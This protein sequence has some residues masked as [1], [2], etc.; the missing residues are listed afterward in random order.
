MAAYCGICVYQ[1]NQFPDEYRGH[2]FMGNI[3]QNAINQDRLT[4]NGSS[5]K[6]TA[7]K[8][9]LTTSDGWFR[10]VSEQVGP[11]GALWIADWYDKYPCYQ[12][13]RADPEGVDR[14][15]GR[16]WRV[17]HNGKDP[18]NKIGSRPDRTM[19]LAKLNNRELVK[20]LEYPNI[21]H[22]RTAQRIL[23][24]RN[25]PRSG[26]ADEP[27]GSP[28]A[29]LPDVAK[30]L[31]KITSN[32]KTLEPRLAALWTLHA[33]NSVKDQ[34]STSPAIEGWPDLLIKLTRAPEPAVKVWAIR[35]LGDVLR[36]AKKDTPANVASAASASYETGLDR[37]EELAADRDPCVRCAVAVACREIVS[38]SLTVDTDL[39]YAAQVRR[40]L[41]RLTASS[42]DA[43]D[44]LIPYMIWM[45][46]E[47][48]FA[49]NPKGGLDWLAN[50]GAQ[51]MPLSGILARKAMRRIC[52]TQDKT[53][54]DI[55]VHFLERVVDTP[56]GV[57]RDAIEG[58]IEGQKAKPLVPNL[59]TTS[60]FARL[61]LS[62]DQHI[63]E[64][65][66]ELGTL[67]GNAASIEA[68]LKT[69]NDATLPV[70]Q[71]RKAI[72]AAKALKNQVARDA[73]LK[74]VNTDKDESLIVEAIRGL[75]DLGS[76]TVSDDLLAS[77]TKFTPPIKTAAAEVL[78]SRHRWAIALLSAIEAKR[79]S[80][81]E[82]PITAVRALGE[83]KD[84]FVRQRAVQAIGRI[85]AANTDKQ[86]IIEEKKTMILKGGLQDLNA[87]H[88]IAKKTCFVCHKLNGEGGEVGPDLTGVGR[89][90][91]DALLANVIDPNLVVGKGYENVIIE[92]KDGQTV[93]GRLV[94]NTD[95]R[96]KLLSL[97]PK[98]EFV[99][100]SDI[101][102]M[103]VSEL[104][105]M[106]EGLE[107]MPDADFRNMM[108]FI[109]E[110]TEK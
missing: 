1:G 62:T 106:P 24:E 60:L 9:F 76:D 46:G 45:A 29:G 108:L 100:K 14:E 99:A 80:P 35:F 87:G 39:D 86:K 110:G 89:S 36:S 51:N 42:K 58:L 54:M 40:V 94:E 4:P 65:G 56:A 73:L 68:T 63:K 17:V 50:D 81:M 69:L 96:V 71:R 26:V 43:R 34:S 109:L 57:A 20:L 19:D 5:F 70:E 61:K 6:A 18:N 2:V 16:I 8:D 7:E 21:W 48:A 78:V 95:S 33:V 66:Q 47:P 107:Q 92:T 74:L 83:S 91:L 105:V 32:S 15:H 97:G 37:L 98:E 77:W 13:A 28:T 67:W 72:V 30:E 41:A 55:V 75:G 82:L 64:R 93:S 23:T 31:E 3:H 22:R 59:D 90:S 103:R 101:Q 12:N 88:Q 11:D 102:N 38:S 52:D 79:I 25:G 85:R 84:D 10:P 53:K 49:Q 27:G 104:S 44:P